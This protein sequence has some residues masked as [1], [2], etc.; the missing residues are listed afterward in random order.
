MKWSHLLD[1]WWRRQSW[2]SSPTLEG[3]IVDLGGGSWST[4]G[5]SSELLLSPCA[6]LGAVAVL[7]ERYI[8]SVSCG[9]E[10]ATFLYFSFDA[11][12]LLGERTGQPLTKTSSASSLVAPIMYYRNIWIC[13]IHSKWLNLHLCLHVLQTSSPRNAPSRQKYGIYSMYLCHH[14]A[15]QQ[16]RSLGPT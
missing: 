12:S 3:A 13:M 15:M 16:T 7:K 1:S 4:G 10:K 9:H 6:S 11:K 14:H 8:C 2:P 5:N